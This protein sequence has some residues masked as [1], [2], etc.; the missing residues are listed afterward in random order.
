MRR[1]GG[2]AQAM[3]LRRSTAKLLLQFVGQSVCR[4]QCAAGN[5]ELLNA[6][7]ADK[8]LR[9]GVR[10]HPGANQQHVATRRAPQAG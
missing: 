2:A 10:L 8:G 7:Q 5:P 6:P 3:D 1:F 9:V 4:R